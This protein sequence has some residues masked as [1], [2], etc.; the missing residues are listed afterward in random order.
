ML[1]AIKA[2]IIHAEKSGF[3]SRENA[4]LVMED[5]VIQG[6]FDTLPAQYQN[7]ALEDY[8][9]AILTPAFADMHLHAPQ[10]PM[11]GL[12]GDLQL[13]DWLND[14]AFPTEAMFADTDFA[15]RVYRQLAQELIKRGTTRVCMFSSLHTDATLILMEELEKA[16]V[17]GL[18]GKV[19]MDRNSGKSLQESTGESIRETLRWL[20]ACGNFRLVKPILTPRFTPACTD[21]LMA[22]L[23][24]L[25][26]ERDLPVQSH[27]SENDNEIAWVKELHPDCAQYWQ[28]YAKYGLWKQG[29]LM[30]HCVHSDAR[31][32]AAMREA[33]VF[34]VHCPDSN[35]NIRSGIAPVRRALQEGVQVVMGTDIAGGVQLNMADALTMAIRMSKQ[36]WIESQG[37][38]DFL[39]FHEAFY[40]ATTAGAAYFG[41]PSGFRAGERLHAQILTDALLCPTLQPLT[42]PERLERLICAAD[43]HS[44]HAVYSDGV[45][46][47]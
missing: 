29:T 43:P 42:L 36:R 18:V 7:A 40:L 34:M 22:A 47:L 6:V 21:E 23:G 39:R 3:V 44:L 38:D 35:V 12:G 13:I 37:Q 28:T 14:Y 20:D 10:Y 17:T 15:R 19:N 9:D 26:R 27:L 24:K 30:A 16:G 31:E 45:Q 5:G 41:V 8:G 11:M 32:R 4:Y 46:R 25:A 2:N 1:Q 33:G